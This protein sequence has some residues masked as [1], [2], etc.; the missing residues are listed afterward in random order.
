MACRPLG[1]RNAHGPDIAPETPGAE[2]NDYGQVVLERRIRDA[3]A[4]LNPSLPSSTLEDAVR[5]LTHPEGAMLEVHNRSFHRML[6]NGVNVEH[7]TD[8][9][10]MRGD[11]ARVIDFDNPDNNDW[12]VVNQ[13]T[14]VE[15]R[16]T[17]RPDVV[18]FLNGLPL[19]VI[20]LKNP[21]DEDATIWT[22]WQQLQTYR[23]ELPS[24]FSMN[25][26]LM[27]SDGL[28]ARIG[29]LGAGREW[30]KPWRI[31]TGETLVLQRRV[32]W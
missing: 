20:E 11:Q 18:L 7:R 19:G 28:N 12:L 23:V 4:K 21:A 5:K 9:G 32:I 31:I 17:R 29:A 2:R 22:A 26:V 10:A 24:L 30:F 1:W 15:N 3:L 16:N 6:V 25:E 8:D 27:V 14:V 13:L